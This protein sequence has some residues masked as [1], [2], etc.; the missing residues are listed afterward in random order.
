MPRIK[1]NMQGRTFYPPNWAG[2]GFGKLSLLSCQSRLSRW[3]A[4][5][6]FVRDEQFFEEDQLESIFYA[7]GGTHIFYFCFRVEGS[8]LIKVGAQLLSG[9]RLGAQ[10]ANLKRAQLYTSMPTTYNN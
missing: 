3:L 9:L 10:F 6:V 7:G 1:S 5:L 8:C 2:D 4:T